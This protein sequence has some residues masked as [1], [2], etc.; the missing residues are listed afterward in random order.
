MHIFIDNADLDIVM[1]IYNLLEYSGN[2][3]MTSGSLG[4]YHRDEVN[5]DSNKNNV[6]INYRI[7]NNKIT[8]SKSSEYKT[9]V[10][11]STPDDNNTVG[12][13]S[14]SSIKIFEYYLKIS[15]FVSD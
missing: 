14:C 2:Y 11:G 15:Q 9:K 10:I 5:D 8:T 13:R 12:H 4:N 3:F 6:A 7:N 1:P